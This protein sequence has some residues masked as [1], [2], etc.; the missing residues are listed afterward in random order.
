M[1]QE[2]IRAKELK[3]KRIL[4]DYDW[5]VLEETVQINVWWCLIV[6]EKKQGDLKVRT[7]KSTKNLF[8]KI[9]SQEVIKA[10]ELRAEWILKDY[11]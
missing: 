3:E 2:V 6:A 5:K 7:S 8:R 1:S 9:M 10:K 11:D 4:K